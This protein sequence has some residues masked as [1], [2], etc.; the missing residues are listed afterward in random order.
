[1]PQRFNQNSLHLLR[2]A[3]GRVAAHERLTI[4][5]LTKRE[6]CSFRQIKTTGHYFET[7]RGGRHFRSRH[8]NDAVTDTRA[9]V[10]RKHPVCTMRKTRA[11]AAEVAS[12]SVSQKH[13]TS[14]TFSTLHPGS[15]TLN[16]L[17]RKTRESLAK[18]K[19]RGKSRKTHPP[20]N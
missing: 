4:H 20:T 6:I 17:L 8:R 18:E 10:H 12:L 1:M 5:F 19:E 14:H 3:G 13:R 11:T 15:G 9:Y 16:L 7:S 2:S